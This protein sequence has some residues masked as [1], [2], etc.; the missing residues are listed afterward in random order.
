MMNAVFENPAVVRLLV[1]PNR[2]S[3]APPEVDFRS[4][5]WL[6]PLLATAEAEV[7]RTLSADSGEFL[8]LHRQPEGE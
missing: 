2:K 6:Q 4:P 7:A 8:E 3:I 1:V 5:Q